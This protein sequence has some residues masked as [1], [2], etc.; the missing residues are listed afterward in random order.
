MGLLTSVSWYHEL[1]P[2]P[3][4]R[5][6]Y[7]LSCLS[8]LLSYQRPEASISSFSKVLWLHSSPFV[9]SSN[10]TATL[11]SWHGST[12]PQYQ[13]LYP[14]SP[15]AWQYKLSHLIRLFSISE[16][17]GSRNPGMLQLKGFCL[18]LSRGCRQAAG[19]DC[20]PLRALPG[21]VDLLTCSLMWLLAGLCSSWLLAGIFCCL[22][23]GP[24][25]MA[26]DNI[27][28]CFSQSEWSKQ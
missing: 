6:V 26:F 7:L 10:A 17:L 22:P 23:R 28:T 4:S 5:S 13:S 27:A 1:P 12:L 18:N 9:A 11:R 21:L 16:A 20:S 3:V 25:C 15:A 14:F 2:P 8:W 24:L 19:Q